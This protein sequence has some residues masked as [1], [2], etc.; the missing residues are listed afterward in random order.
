MKRAFLI[1]SAVVLMGA[2]ALSVTRS[3][4]FEARSV[5]GPSVPGAPVH[6]GAKP[7]EADVTRA[8]VPSK[9]GTVLSKSGELASQ[10]FHGGDLRVFAEM[11]KRYPES[12][13][14]AYAVGVAS[15]CSGL[16]T[17]ATQLRRSLEGAIAASNTADS[18]RRL[19]E[20]GELERACASYS[21][22]ELALR[23]V[24]ALR[25]E[26]LKRGDPI[27]LYQERW[28]GRGALTTEEMRVK[29]EEGLRLRDPQ[30]FVQWNA[31]G[32]RNEEN[33]K[34]VGF[35]DGERFGGVSERAYL[36]A[37]TLL[38]CLF[39]EDCGPASHEVKMVCAQSGRCADSR[40]EL[41]KLALSGSPGEYEA[42][43][44]VLERLRNVVLSADAKA[45]LP[46]G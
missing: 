19:R 43:V 36:T 21:A 10:M 41:E 6:S 17:Q 2:A 26:G 3:D 11:A 12:G 39:G 24:L 5:A 22:D 46:P 44:R 30:L 16:S 29:I 38:P 27:L 33:G 20:L 23:S 7:Y 8:A 34:T 42:M 18:L 25:Q 32:F 1:A 31:F 45:L 14:F 4:R 13:G 28:A 15:Y 37:W 9:T 40:F 35:L